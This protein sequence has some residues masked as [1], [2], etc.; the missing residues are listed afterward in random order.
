MVQLTNVLTEFLPAG[1]ALQRYLQV[2]APALFL[3]AKKKKTRS[4]FGFS[5]NSSPDTT[6]RPFKVPR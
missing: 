4:R 2:E 6:V 1:L 3:C 5:T